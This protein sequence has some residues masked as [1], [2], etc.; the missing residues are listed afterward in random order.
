MDDLKLCAKNER[1]LDS[2]IQT[3]RIFSDD[4][5]VVFDLDKCVLLVLKRGKMVQKEGIESPDF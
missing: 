5:G 2:F 1:E 3:V 4:V